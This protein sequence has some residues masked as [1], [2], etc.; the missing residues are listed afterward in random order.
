MLQGKIKKTKVEKHEDSFVPAS[1]LIDINEI[2]EAM[3]EQ[4]EFE[5]SIEEEVNNNEDE[6]DFLNEHIIICGIKK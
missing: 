3:N 4:E 2:L 1:S 5:K 6:L